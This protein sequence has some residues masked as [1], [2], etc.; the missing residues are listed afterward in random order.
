MSANQPVA[1]QPTGQ[2]PNR[3]LS[4]GAIAA[5]VVG[6]LVAS[7]AVFGL[8]A[9]LFFLGSLRVHDALE[10]ANVPVLAV[11][12]NVND[13]WTQRVL[14]EVY[15]ASVDALVADKGVIERLG[16]PVE[17]DIA[18]E[19]LF[20]RVN[21]GELDPKHEAI[22]FDVLGPKGR[23][24]VRVTASGVGEY[25]RGD[26]PLQIKEIMVTLDD[27]TSI[28]VEPPPQRNVQVR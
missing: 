17:T 18:A 5:L 3:A 6:A 11:R 28:E 16:D 27:G 24:T 22:E 1:S 9:G 8:C 23:A 12:P 7:L 20:V 13:W 4:A 26:T 15:T 2:R 21:T 10:Q 25:S 14:S 19:E